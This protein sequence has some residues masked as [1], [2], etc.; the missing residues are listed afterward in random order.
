M[1]KKYQGSPSRTVD[2]GWDLERRTGATYEIVSAEPPTQ[3]NSAGIDQDGTDYSYF[4]QVHMGSANTTLYMLL[5]SGASQSWVMGSTCTSP[6]CEVHNTFGPADSSTYKPTGGEFLLKYGS[7]NAT[8]TYANDSVSLAGFTLEM[9]LGIANVTSDD[10]L[11]F[12]IDGILGLAQ[13]PSQQ[14]P[15][16]VETL[17]ASKTFTS[18]LFAVILNR[19]SDG[20]GDYGEISFGTTDPSKYTGSFSYT[21]ISPDAQGGWAIP[22][23][24]VGFGG[25]NAGISGKLAYID[26]GTSFIFAPQDE[27]AQFHQTVPGAQSTDGENWSVPCSTTTPLTFTFSGVGWNVASQDWVG[28]MANGVCTS[29]VYGS[30]VV[31]GQWLLGDTFL[32]SVY[33][34]FDIDENRIGKSRS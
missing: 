29:N 10:F 30:E 26:T 23:D 1:A 21:P 18:N 7:G 28:P 4:A 3:T 33:T 27:V 20:N 22:M 5:D 25:K 17:V 8:G 32:K 11:S 15:T 9:T 34:V 2:N 24:S 19:A 31:P 6:A 16:F 14:Y 12:P 13:G